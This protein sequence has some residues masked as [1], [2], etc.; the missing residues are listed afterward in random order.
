MAVHFDTGNPQQLL[1]KFDKAVALN[2][3]KGGIAT[4]SKLPSGHYT[5]DAAQWKNKAFFLPTISAGRLTFNIINPKNQTIGVL[6]YAYYH[7]HL[8]ETM[9]HHFEHD[10][11]TAAATAQVAAG[12]KVA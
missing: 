4:W 5:H 3:Q 12:D 9:L 2:N 11:Y 7:G 6:T 8:I 1:A 10:F